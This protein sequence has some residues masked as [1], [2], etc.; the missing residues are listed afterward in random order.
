ML[1]YPRQLVVDRINIHL[2]QVIY[3]LRTD[4][5]LSI[6]LRLKLEDFYTAQAFLRRRRIGG[7]TEAEDFIYD[8]QNKELPSQT[9]PRHLAGD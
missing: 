4:T 7:T 2:E 8:W 5:Q 1:P 3:Q 9:R 6:C